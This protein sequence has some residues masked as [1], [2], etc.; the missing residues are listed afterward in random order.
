MCAWMCYYDAPTHSNK[1]DK[2]YYVRRPVPDT[3]LSCSGHESRLPGGKTFLRACEDAGDPVRFRQQR[4]I[5][6]GETET[7]QQARQAA[8]Q[9]RWFGEYREGGGVAESHSRK[10]QVTEFPCWGLDDWG[11]VV[12]NKN[13]SSERGGQETETREC[14]GYDGLRVW[15][16]DELDRNF[17]TGCGQSNLY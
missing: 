17:V 5:N 8:R 1:A 15:P 7:R 13:G 10:D 16:L 14:Y 6:H 9:P 11:V 12:A 4:S 2:T 3:H